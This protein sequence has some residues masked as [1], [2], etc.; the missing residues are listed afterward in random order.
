MD[1]QLLQPAICG[2][3]M[4]LATGAVL[5]AAPAIWHEGENYTAV[6]PALGRGWEEKSTASGGKALYGATLGIKGREVKYVVPVDRTFTEAKLVF[7]YARLHWK[8]EMQPAVT[9]CEITVAGKI[10]AYT[11]VFDH[12]GGWG[13]DS[14]KEWGIVELR[15]GEIKAGP[16]EVRLRA[17]DDLGDAVIDGFWLAPQDLAFTADEFKPLER[18]SISGEGYVGIVLESQAVEQTRFSGGAVAGRGFSRREIHI[19][20]QLQDEK[21]QPAM[22]LCQDQPLVLAQDQTRLPLPQK[23]VRGLADGNYTLVAAGDNGQTLLSIP[24]TA[25]GDLMAAA[26]I[27]RAEILNC[28]SARREVKDTAGVL[29]DLEY[30][31]DYLDNSLVLLR[32]RSGLQGDESAQKRALAYFEKAQRR[33]ARSFAA[34]LRGIMAQSTET[35]ARLQSKADPYQGRTGD[36]RRA[37]RSQATGKLEPYR[38]YIPTM[39]RPGAKVPVL[40]AL[41][42]GGGDENQFPDL[43]NGVLNGIMERRG[44]IMVSPKAT[45]GY[46]D[47]G[48]KDMAQLVELVWALYPDTDRK[49]TYC[50]GVSMGGSGTYN[51]AVTYPELFAGIACVSGAGG[52]GPNSTI[53][54]LKNIP[55]LLLHGGQDTVVPVMAAQTVADKLKELGYVHELRIFPTYGHNYH[56]EEYMAVTL[57]F[58]DKYCKDGKK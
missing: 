29:A 43:D 12:T 45:S 38:I 10:R 18:I 21:N 53:Q 34:D 32:S 48:A 49:Q 36:L 41:H 13:S 23:P 17:Q 16:L 56:G 1:M 31:A 11:V 50:T 22:V 14:G 47:N 51:L 27:K 39:Y 19:T 28:L 9:A 33:T 5:A 3:T 35:L 24:V 46:R 40:L 8:K 42:G 54:N 57:E 30:A 7:R 6:D 37:F 52:R 26:E 4:L 58:F 55:T 44:M 2:L 20:V 15:I 25:L